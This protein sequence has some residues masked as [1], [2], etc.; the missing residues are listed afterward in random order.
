MSELEENTMVFMMM[1]F[2]EIHKVE[3]GPPKEMLSAKELSDRIA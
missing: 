1:A 2:K 3:I